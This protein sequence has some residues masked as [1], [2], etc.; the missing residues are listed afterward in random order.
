MKSDKIFTGI[1]P[2]LITP[3]DDD[4]EKYTLKRDTV[5][6]LCKWEL[7]CGVNGFYICGSTGEGPVLGTKLRMEMAEAV[8]ESVGGRCPIINHIGAPSAEDAVALVKHSDSIGVDAISSVVPNFYFTY[9]DD[10]TVDYYKRIASYTDKPIIIYAQS[11]MKTADIPALVKRIYEIDT[12]TGVKF[13]IPNYYELHRIREMCEGINII[14]GPDETLTCGLLMGADAGIGT[15]YN[16]MPVWFT[17]LYS[18]FKAGNIAGAA[19][20][21]FKINRVIEAI[22]RNGT[23]RA[24]K[25]ALNLMG[26]D[27]GNAA[28]PTK[29]MPAE[30]LAAFKTELESYGICFEI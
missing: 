17:E 15:T 12:V 4:G 26:F 28:F 3:Y 6:K 9:N 21:Q 25:E 18:T 22:I 24:T 5:D 23:I 2:A 20:V 19:Q 30:Q 14:N 8:I 16:V 10:E 11:L 13:T 27:C 1:M 29:K 7:S